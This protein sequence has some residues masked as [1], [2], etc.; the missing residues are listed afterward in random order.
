MEKIS[1]SKV[2]TRFAQ[3]PTGTLH[4]GGVGQLYLIIYMQNK[5]MEST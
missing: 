5:I 3:S 4:I 2:V 1:V